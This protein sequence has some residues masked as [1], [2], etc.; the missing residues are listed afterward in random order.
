MVNPRPIGMLHGDKM[1]DLLDGQVAWMDPNEI[2]GPE[3]TII[4]IPIVPHHHPPVHIGVAFRYFPFF[5]LIPAGMTT[6]RR[7]SGGR[8]RAASFFPLLFMSR[9]VL[10]FMNSQMSRSDDEKPNQNSKLFSSNECLVF[11]PLRAVL[12]VRPPPTDRSDR[13]RGVWRASYVPVCACD[14]YLPRVGVRGWL[15]VG[16]DISAVIHAAETPRRVGVV[17]WCGVVVVVVDV[18]S[19]IPLS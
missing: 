3:M 13:F 15:D 1:A 7:E 14:L 12:G 10:F 19:R 16:I 2:A 6:F 4:R 5:F 9:L 17:R 11:H 18:W 8:E